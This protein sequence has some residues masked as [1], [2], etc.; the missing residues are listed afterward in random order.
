MESGAKSYSSSPLGVAVK[1]MLIILLGE[2]IIMTTMEGVFTPL[3]GKSTS[4]L[5]WEFLDPLLLTLIVAPA[6]H[7][8]VVRPMRE[9]QIT[10]ERQKEELGVAAVTFDAHD[11]VIVT[12]AQHVI[13]RV[14][15]AFSAITG[16]SSEEVVGRTPSIL[17]S[18]RQDAKFYHKM[19]ERLEQD[20]HWEGEIW[21]RR[22]NGEIYPEW[23][24]ITAVAGAAGGAHYVGIFSDISKRK[25]Y[26]EKISFLAYHDRLTTLPSRELFYEKLSRAMSKVRRKKDRLALLYLDLDGFKEV[27]DNLGHEA[28]DTVLKVSAKRLSGCVRSED[29]VARLGG[30]EFAIVLSGIESREDAGKVAEKVIGALSNPVQLPGGEECSVGVSI[31]IA[32]YP[33]NGVEIDRLMSAADDAMYQSKANGKNRYTFSHVMLEEEDDGQ[34]WVMLGKPHLCGVP[35]LD[36]AHLELANLL[37]ALNAAVRGNAPQPETLQLLDKLATRIDEHFCDEERL[38]DTYGFSDN[39]AHRHEHRSLLDELVLLKDKFQ[40][41]GEMLVLYSLKEW[42]LGHIAGS[43]KLLADFILRQR[44]Q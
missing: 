9:Q 14:N 1:V 30:D 4:P 13:L 43:D 26:E 40:H 21:N 17:Q 38:M 27:N 25:S 19:R 16:Y 41:G 20:G 15:R 7:F 11:G 33:D 29:T 23:L 5:F 32:I 28:G 35:E 36:T 22:K 12:D 24:T 39:D 37:N 10:L 18:G 2:F 44:S 34:S 42:L 31:G 6:F 8:L 3:S